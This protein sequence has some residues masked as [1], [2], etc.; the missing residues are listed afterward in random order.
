MESEGDHVVAV[1]HP[2]QCYR[3]KQK[4]GSKMNI[5]KRYRISLRWASYILELEDR[6]VLSQSVSILIVAGPNPRV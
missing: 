1:R 3:V 6:H 2:R 4:V 5:G